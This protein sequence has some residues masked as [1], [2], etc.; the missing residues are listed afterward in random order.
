MHDVRIVLHLHEA[1]HLHGTDASDAADV[2]A[3]EVCQHQVF[4]ALLLVRQQ[5]ALKVGIFRPVAPA[6]PRARDRVR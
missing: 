3:P 6:R 5:L 4:G 2:V 1:G